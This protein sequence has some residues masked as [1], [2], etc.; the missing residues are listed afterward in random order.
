[1][2]ANGRYPPIRDYAFISD[3]HASAL[4][5]R[6]GSIDW[7]CMPRFDSS[8]VFGRL[9]D[10]ERGGFCRIAPVEEFA[11]TR[12]YV[13]QSLVLSTMFE[14]DTG[15][16][17]LFDCFTTRR[18]GAQSPYRQLLRVVEGRRGRVTFRIHL[19]PR[20]DYAEVR[21]WVR[22]HGA[23]LYT[24]IGGNDALAIRCDHELELVDAHDLVAE[25]SVR[26]GERVRLAVH[27]LQPE[28]IDPEPPE[29]PSAEELDARLES[30]VAWWKRWARRATLHGAYAPDAV[31]SALVLKGLTHAPTGAVVA[32]ATT[33]LPEALKQERNWDYRY[34]W[35]RD[36]HFT[37]RSLTELGYDAEAD[38]FRRFVERSA[39]ASVESLQIM[40]G[41]GGERRIPELLLD[42]LDGYRGSRPV[43]I[44]N[45]ASRQMQFDVFGDLLDLSAQWHDRGSSPDD[46][47]W[48][49]LVSVVNFVAD[50]W[51][52]PDKG[53]WE[54][55]GRPKH[56][57]YSKAMCWVALDR[58]VRL[59]KE[60]MREAPVTRW[61]RER[62]ALRRVLDDE[63]F[64]A[65]RNAFTQALRGRALD[66]SALL[67]PAFGVVNYDDPRMIGT[68]DAIREELMDGSLVRRY[69]T[70]DSLSGREGTFLPCTFWLA[71]CL[72]YQGR[73]AEAQEVFDAAL[74]TTN[75]VGLFAEEFDEQHQL[76]LGNFPQALTHLSHITAAVALTRTAT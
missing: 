45:A 54:M 37:V 70:K 53:I 32:A 47:Y 46:D 73:T 40:Y 13:D 43:R 71:E 41:V 11:T 38:G 61:E 68:V 33:S 23:G 67:L 55:R 62:K 66:A 7:C 9:L 69:N 42:D 14:T 52:Q 58:G 35:I 27:Y 44:G 59:A 51:R 4:V 76:A 3:C 72:A 63:G 12:H 5:S 19:A 18:G 75:D 49:F 29:P 57:V 15:E 8:P 17:E 16:V 34:S 1:M 36:S 56:F 21:P 26:P 28:T 2:H 25:C 74:A 6:Q 64:N 22:H 20:F 30:T 31:R 24:A 39:A 60:C 10:W 48:R 50:H 65:R